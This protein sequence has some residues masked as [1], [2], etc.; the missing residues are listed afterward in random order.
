M[1]LLILSS[2]L[3]FALCSLSAQSTSATYEPSPIPPGQSEFERQVLSNLFPVLE[4]ETWD[5]SIEN[6]LTNG[7]Q[8]F[9]GY[10]NST[11]FGE[12]ELETILTS[13]RAVKVLNTLQ[14]LP[15]EERIQKCRELFDR[16]MTAHEDVHL[17]DPEKHRGALTPRYAVS[18]AL[19]ATA[20]T[21]RRDVLAEEFARLDEFEKKNAIHAEKLFTNK[22][23]RDF[24]KEVWVPQQRFQLNV[25]RLAVARDPNGGDALQ[26][27]D[28]C[29]LSN[30]MTAAEFPIARWDSRT[31]WNQLRWLR[32]ETKDDQLYDP[33][34]FETPRHSKTLA[35][36]REVMDR[37]KETIQGMTVYLLYDWDRSYYVR[38]PETVARKR[39]IVQ[40][41]RALAL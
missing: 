9:E 29:C 3:A 37:F 30:K 7:N 20:D 39:E 12:Y 17:S 27:I 36:K 5:Q 1:K 13:K 32:L 8:Y 23:M 38:M 34:D 19:F 11:S 28:A 24:Q 31:V 26:K 35:E 40:Q 15:P 2:S 33:E 4:K 10:I 25:L 21:G 14:A 6:L 16:V 18:L 41:V 22:F